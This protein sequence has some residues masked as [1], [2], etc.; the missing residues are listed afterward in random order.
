MEMSESTSRI[1][2]IERI[3]MLCGGKNNND[4]LDSYNGVTFV[5]AEDDSF[6]MELDSTFY[7]RLIGDVC[8]LEGAS[9]NQF[10]W[11]WFDD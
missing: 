2:V 1:G 10:R 7:W 5:Q 3:H 8:G 9:N 4:M 11:T 6:I